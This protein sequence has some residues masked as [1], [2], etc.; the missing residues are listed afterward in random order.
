MY[1]ERKALSVCFFSHSP[2]LNGGERSLLELTTEL[3]KDHGVVCSVILPG[4]GPLKEKLEEVGASTY[5]VSYSWWS[6]P[7]LLPEEEVNALC[8]NSAQSILYNIKQVLTKINP[9]VIVTNTIAIPWG[10]ITASFLSKPHVWFIREFGEADHN[11]KTFLPFNVT[12]DFIKNSSAL[13][14]TNSDVVR[15][16]LFP[17]ISSK[18]ALTIYSYVNIPSTTLLQNDSSYFTEPNSTKL[19][20]AG[21]VKAG[22]GQK[23]AI[24]AVKELV[25]GDRDVELIIMGDCTTEYAEN[26][27]TI[28]SEEKLE[29]HIKFIGFK[30]NP[31]PIMNQADIVLVCS[32]KEAFGRVTVEGMLL[33]KPIIGTNTGGT[34]ELIKDGFNGLLYE[35]GDYEQLAAK[36]EYL[37]DRPD[38]AKWLAENGH[39]FANKTFTRN[40]FGGKVYKLLRNLKRKSTSQAAC[41]SATLK[42]PAII[43]TLLSPTATKDPKIAALITEFGSSPTTKDTQIS[44]L[45]T[46]LQE[47]VTYIA[48]L[49]TRLQAQIHSLESQIQRFQQSIPIQLVNRY[50]RIVE[51]LLRSGTRRRY[52]YELMLSGIRVILN[53]GWHIFVREARNWLRE[54]KYNENTAD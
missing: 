35:P 20:I 3:I 2:Y 27:K 10:A 31:Y 19:I 32:R 54:R 34:P 13:I 42:G 14:V 11:L 40:Q 17:G 26:L 12:L 43:E 37:I 53:K 29:K 46:S 47:K 21:P 33:K 48:E 25:Q 16:T 8:T 30:E 45:E 41:F 4:D 28:V 22:K 44:S 50:Q 15:K 39:E 24:L 51:R 36:I 9:D 23:D 18:K 38:K 5:V 52:Y 1:K 49:E 6:D 7:E